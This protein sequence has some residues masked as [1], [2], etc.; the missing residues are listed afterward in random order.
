M[1]PA[2]VELPARDHAQ[3]AG[4]T[5]GRT[6]CSDAPRRNRFGH[7]KA[8]RTESEHR[9]TRVLEIELPP[10]DF[11]NVREQRS[12]VATIFYDKVREVLEEVVL[13][14]VSKS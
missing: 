10:I 13:V 2:E 7:V 3:N 8:L 4:K 9:R 5:T 6:T 11:G 14:E 1:N 12:G